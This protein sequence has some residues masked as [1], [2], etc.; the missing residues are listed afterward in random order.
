MGYTN[1]RDYSEG[2]EGWISAGLPVEAAPEHDEAE[3]KAIRSAVE[4]KNVK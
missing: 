2:K 1:V 3:N 4:S